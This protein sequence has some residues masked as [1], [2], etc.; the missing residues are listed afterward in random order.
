[1][2]LPEDIRLEIEENEGFDIADE[3][4]LAGTFCVPAEQFEDDGYYEGVRFKG[5]DLTFH[6]WAKLARL[7]QG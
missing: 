2:E 1:M 7:G 3:E 4:L 6:Y 5:E